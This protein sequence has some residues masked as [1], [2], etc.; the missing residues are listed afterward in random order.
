MWLRLVV[1]RRRGRGR[2]V[3]PLAAYDSLTGADLERARATI[4][5]NPGGVDVR[6]AGP[7]RIEVVVVPVLRGSVPRRYGEPVDRLVVAAE[8]PDQAAATAFDCLRVFAAR[9]QVREGRVAVLA[10]RVGSAS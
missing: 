7:V 8:D 1:V 9:E 4:R 5:A 10:R 3:N 6:E 2:V